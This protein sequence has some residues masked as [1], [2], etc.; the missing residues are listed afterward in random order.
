MHVNAAWFDLIDALD[1][2]ANMIELDRI[3]QQVA[4][5]RV[6][7]DGMTPDA[8]VKWCDRY[9]FD[10]HGAIVAKFAVDH[11]VPIARTAPNYDANFLLAIEQICLTR[12]DD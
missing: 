12:C 11:I 2:R 8:C 4:F 5:I 1:R 6:V 3:A 7:S 10:D 9:G